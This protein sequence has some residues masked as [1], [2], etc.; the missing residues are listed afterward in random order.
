[1]CLDRENIYVGET[2]AGKECDIMIDQRNVY[3][4][5]IGET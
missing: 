3:Y 1:M 4:S 2:S 5:V